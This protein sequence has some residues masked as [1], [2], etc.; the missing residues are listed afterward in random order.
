MSEAKTDKNEDTTLTLQLRAPL[1]PEIDAPKIESE[2]GGK[3]E[4]QA[5]KVISQAPGIVRVDYEVEPAFLAPLSKIILP[6]RKENIKIEIVK[7]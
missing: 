2:I 5:T 3:S 1:V 6:I 7:E 4:S